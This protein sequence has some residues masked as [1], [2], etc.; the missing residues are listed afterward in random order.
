[1]LGKIAKTIGGIVIVGGVGLVSYLLIAPP[2]L[3]KVGTNYSAKIVCSNVFIAGRDPD[4]VLAVDVQAP[5]HPLLKQVSIEVDQEAQTV[6]ARLFRFFA[7]ATS[8]YR[9]GLGCTNVHDVA[10]STQTLEAPG[11]LPAGLWPKGNDVALSQDAKVQAVMSDESLLGEGYRAVVVVRNGRIVAE[12]YADGFNAQTPL[13]GW[14]MTKSVTAGLIGTLVEAGEMSLTDN[15]VGSFPDW[16]EDS[17]RDISLADMLSMTSGLNWDEEY[18]DVSDVTRMLYLSDDM[19]GFAADRAPEAETGTDFNYSSGTTTVLSRVWQDQLPDGGLTYPQTALFEPLG[20]TS[21]VLETD[22]NDTFIGSSYMYATA[23]DWARFGQL[24]LQKGVWDNTRVLPE[25]F[26]DWMV[27]PVAASDGRYAK[28]H[29]WLESPGDFPPFE[30]A[31]WLQ[32]HDGQFIG[33]FPS[34]DMI[35]LRMGLTPSR[36]RY[37]SLPLAQAL[38]T[39][40]GDDPS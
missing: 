19:A 22:A 37:S 8:Q 34:H 12:R 36:L 10:L 28:G 6:H 11:P 27:E 29:L 32:G 18:G 33:V 5:G 39:A 15:L 23:R 20:M 30:D 14:S 35:V 3:L 1:M 16:A 31:Y 26:V 24:L 17:R 7:P 9:D 25:G 4:E 2:D 13:L 21:A 40:F 38:I